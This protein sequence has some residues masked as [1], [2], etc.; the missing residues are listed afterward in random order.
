MECTHQNK[1]KSNCRFDIE[2]LKR[3][4]CSTSNFSIDSKRSQCHLN[5]CFKKFW[6]WVG[7]NLLKKRWVK[8]T[9]C[10]NA[11]HR[12]QSPWRGSPCLTTN[13]LW[14]WQGC[15]ISLGLCFL[16][17]KMRRWIVSSVCSGKATSGL[18]DRTWNNEYTGLDRC[19]PHDDQAFRTGIG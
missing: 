2:V 12:D 18:E 7:S 11:R 1:L 16:I 17:C 3:K 13:S 10:Q 15:S 14:L 19:D 8:Y 9:L 4:I 6:L 5:W